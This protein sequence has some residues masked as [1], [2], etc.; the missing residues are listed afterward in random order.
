MPNPKDN[1]LI[2]LASVAGLGIQIALAVT[3]SAIIFIGIGSW[4]DGLWHTKPILTFVGIISGLLVSLAVVWHLMKPFLQK[5]KEG[6]Q[7]LQKYP[8]KDSNI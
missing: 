2:S 5:A 3:I 1:S 8:K 6:Y 4:L 7:I